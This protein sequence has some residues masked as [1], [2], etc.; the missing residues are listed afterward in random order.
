MAQSFFSVESKE[1]KAIQSISVNML[2]SRYAIAPK[3][4]EQSQRNGSGAYK[5]RKR[6]KDT[7]EG[8][9]NQSYC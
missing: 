1:L 6:I 7:D 2:M 3:P 5:I 8:L 9:G 4:Q